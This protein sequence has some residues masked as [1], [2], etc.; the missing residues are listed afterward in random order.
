MLKTAITVRTFGER[1]LPGRHLIICRP[2]NAD[3]LA[4]SCRIRP[5][6]SQQVRVSSGFS[7]RP[8]SLGGGREN[9]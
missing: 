6:Q 2:L 7:W 3:A 9:G 1:A 8:L 4:K 5:D